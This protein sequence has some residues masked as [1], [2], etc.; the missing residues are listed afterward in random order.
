MFFSD[1]RKQM[2][3]FTSVLNS[4]A[5]QLV[6]TFSLGAGLSLLPLERL[7]L[8]IGAIISV[9]VIASFVFVIG[10]VYIYSETYRRAF[11]VFGDEITTVLGFVLLFA[12]A[13]KRNALTL[14]TLTAVFMSGGKASFVLI[15]LML[16]LFL[17]MQRRSGER[18]AEVRRLFGLS[19]LAIIIYIACQSL[20]LSL[21]N[22]QAFIST[23]E[24]L[25]SGLEV[26]RK[27]TTRSELPRIGTACANLSNCVDSQLGNPL[28]QRYY[29]S[30][31]GLWMTMQGGFPGK[32]YPGTP[33][34]FADLMVASN[35]WGMNDR[36]HLSWESWRWMGG[37]QNPYLGFGSG[38]GPIALLAL[39]LSFLSVAY[40]AWS[41][42]RS[43]QADASAVFSVFFIVNVIVNWTQSWLMSGSLILIT[44]GL[45]CS[46]IFI[47][48]ALR[49]PLPTT[50]S[51]V[52]QRLVFKPAGAGASGADRQ[53]AMRSRP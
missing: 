37:V 44:L 13:T 36:Y 28:L 11:F 6:L 15:V 31:A 22:T 12:I 50:G 17:F 39:G 51:E 7:I 18:Y 4:N 8:P 19:A 10:E 42:L 46:Q 35:P 32:S 52:L 43:G 25:T 29:T 48:A 41:N 20:S 9:C 45:C 5:V 26:M 38:Y 1:W 53:T 34:K 2:D 30:L 49:H 40:L 24:R 27:G 21:M 16:S 3:F 33:E 23:H 14:L 47:S